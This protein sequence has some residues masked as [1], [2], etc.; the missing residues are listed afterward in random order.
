LA[1]VKC[2][3]KPSGGA[4]T[5]AITYE[6]FGISKLSFSPEKDEGVVLLPQPIKLIGE[7]L[8]R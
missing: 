6:I 8:T 2:S 7:K 3:F 4:G 5:V 1:I